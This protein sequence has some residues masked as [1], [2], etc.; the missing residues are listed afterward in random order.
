M[1]RPS[2]FAASIAKD[3]LVKSVEHWQTGIEN[4]NRTQNSNRITRSHWKVSKKPQKKIK[5]VK[6]SAAC[7]SMG[8]FE[9]GSRTLR[10]SK[11]E[12]PWMHTVSRANNIHR[13]STACIQ[14]MQKVQVSVSNQL[15]P[16]SQ[17][18]SHL[19]GIALSNVLDCI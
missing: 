11:L 19:P 14:W 6:I 9:Q 3:S 4:R 16:G 12:A 5:F 17:L 7:R 8:F 1:T 2:D 15:D 18:V 13:I 10:T